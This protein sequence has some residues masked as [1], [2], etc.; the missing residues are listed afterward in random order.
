MLLQ[1]FS[2]FFSMGTRCALHGKISIMVW[3]QSGDV[4]FVPTRYLGL[5]IDWNVVAG[6]AP[7]VLSAARKY[8]H[9]RT[10]LLRK[11]C[12]RSFTL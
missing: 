8:A 1:N 2:R 5:E 3:Y 11:F 6:A 12:V 4:I 9:Y 7:A 10:V